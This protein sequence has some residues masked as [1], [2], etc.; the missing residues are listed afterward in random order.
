MPIYAGLPLPLRNPLKSSVAQTRGVQQ[1]HSSLDTHLFDR[2][3]SEIV[4]SS[5]HCFGPTAHC[6]STPVF[7]AANQS[8]PTRIHIEDAAIGDLW[9][10]LARFIYC[11]IQLTTA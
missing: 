1:V 7:K 6:E 5:P 4:S 3:R 11:G 2:L 8:R 9:R 10:Q